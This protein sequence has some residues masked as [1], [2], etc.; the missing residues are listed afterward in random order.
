MDAGTI[1][2]IAIGV[3]GIA[4]LTWDALTCERK[5]RR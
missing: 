3:A 4:Y 1:L 5:D 2:A